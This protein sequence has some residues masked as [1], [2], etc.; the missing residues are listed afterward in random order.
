MT[1]Q[2]KRDYQKLKTMDD[3][4]CLDAPVPVDAATPFTVQLTGPQM[5]LRML[6]KPRYGHWLV[7]HALS[8]LYHCLRDLAH[9]DRDMTGIQS[10][11]N[12]VYVTVRHGPVISQTDDEWHFDGFSMRSD[13]IPDRSYIWASHCPT[14]Y[15]IGSLD[16][17]SDF[18]PLRHN[19]FTYAARQLAAA[20]IQTIEARSWY[21][22]NPFCLHRRPPN[23]PAG[24]RTFIRVSFGE[25]EIRDA[26]NTPNPLLYTP[27][28]GRDPV[29]SFRN[30]LI[31]YPTI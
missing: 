31:D 27:T 16:I 10:D 26:N 14:Q 29:K 28:Y 5:I 13:E 7:P 6:V 15:K 25:T 1:T 2:F 21:M 19:L 18:D 22:L 9:I 20:P 30:Q 11:H 23:P 4:R 3:F 8:W 12:W 17:P 24:T